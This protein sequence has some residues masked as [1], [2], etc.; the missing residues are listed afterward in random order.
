MSIFK[1]ARSL[2]GP[3]G[4]TSAVHEALAEFLSIYKRIWLSFFYIYKERPINAMSP[5]LNPG[6][7]AWMHMTAWVYVIS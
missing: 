2:R 6:Q 1:R 4:P 5:E 3:Q 7:P